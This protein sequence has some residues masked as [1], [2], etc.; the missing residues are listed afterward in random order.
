MYGINGYKKLDS[1]YLIS[2]FMFEINKHKNNNKYRIYLK[3]SLIRTLNIKTLKTTKE[4]CQ[5]LSPIAPRDV[6]NTKADSAGIE[7]IKNG[8]KT[9]PSIPIDSNTYFLDDTSL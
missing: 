2:T 7:E 4:N 3:S 5:S 1:G 8:N 6:A 9:L